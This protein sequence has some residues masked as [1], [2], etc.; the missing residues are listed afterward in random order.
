[1]VSTITLKVITKHATNLYLALSS[2][3]KCTVSLCPRNPLSDRHPVTAALVTDD[4]L[5]NC[6]PETYITVLINV[7]PIKSINKIIISKCTEIS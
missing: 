2:P 1:M 4:V 5:Q 3:R 6:T 7:A